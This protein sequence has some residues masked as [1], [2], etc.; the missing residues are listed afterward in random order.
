[1][2][3]KYPD[4]HKKYADNVKIYKAEIAKHSD[5][6]DGEDRA[7]NYCEHAVEENRDGGE[8]LNYISHLGEDYGKYLFESPRDLYM[9]IFDEYYPGHDGK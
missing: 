1:M 5:L 8:V 6:A 2:A 3:S 7:H 9:H 4:T